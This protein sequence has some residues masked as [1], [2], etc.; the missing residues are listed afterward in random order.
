MTRL[1]LSFLICAGYKYSPHPMRGEFP[2]PIRGGLPASW[3]FQAGFGPDSHT[4]E[5]QRDSLSRALPDFLSPKAAIIILE[6][7]GKG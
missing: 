4:L 2:W 5:M 1:L 7:L 6:G 3:R